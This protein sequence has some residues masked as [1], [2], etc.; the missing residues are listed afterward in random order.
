MQ[1]LKIVVGDSKAPQT[2]LYGPPP[3]LE[4]ESVKAPALCE[5]M[6]L[7]CIET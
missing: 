2:G 4:K 5:E 7:E 6:H 1:P 3:Y